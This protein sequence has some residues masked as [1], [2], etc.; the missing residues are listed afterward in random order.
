MLLWIFLSFFLA[1]RATATESKALGAP[2][3]FFLWSPTA[4]AAADEVTHLT[5]SQDVHTAYQ[6]ILNEAANHEVVVLLQNAKAG[7]CLRNRALKD[8]LDQ[9]PHKTTMNYVYTSDPA[10]KPISESLSASHPS[11]PIDRLV[12]S[13]TSQKNNEVLVN[14]QPDVFHAV[15][16]EHSA[17]SLK[18]LIDLAGKEKILL[19]AYD[20]PQRGMAAPRRLGQYRM[21]STATTSNSSTISTTNSS[22][23]YYKPEGAEYAIYYA[24]TYLY[25][26][27]DIFTGLITAIFFFFVGW[28]GISCLGDIQ[29]NTYF[30]DKLPVVGKEA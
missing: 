29:G 9:A 24:D 8:S 1:C 4:T 2:G 5:V 18:K 27:P 28:I 14:G 11:Q 13:L 17:A 25:I 22:S 6:T 3:K 15:Y 16:D 12:K 7:S 26:T 21:L 19:V 10:A 30:Y 23:I 20:E